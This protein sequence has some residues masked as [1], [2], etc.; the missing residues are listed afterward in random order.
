M[1]HKIDKMLTTGNDLFQ[2]IRGKVGPLVANLDTAVQSYTEL[3]KHLD[4]RTE[5]LSTSAKG[6]LDSFDATLK[7][8]R[9]A[10]VKFQK[11][12][13]SDSPTVLDLNRALGEIAKSAQAIRELAD[14]LERH[15]E[16][17]IQGK[18]GPKR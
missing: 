5:G 8:S 7:E 3:A 13:N 18:G 9:S 6:A 17:L 11:I 16:A 14:Y 10:I 12:V 2:E 4:H 1:P 15:P